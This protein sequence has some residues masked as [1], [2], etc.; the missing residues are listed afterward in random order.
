MMPLSWSVSK[1]CSWRPW[2]PIP[3]K[4]NAAGGGPKMATAS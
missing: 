2:S 1:V 4:A 3:M